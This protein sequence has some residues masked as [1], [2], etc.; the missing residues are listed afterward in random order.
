VTISYRFSGDENRARGIIYDARL[1][2]DR[3]KLE[4]SFNSLSQLSRSYPLESG[5]LIRV[6]SHF[7]Q[8]SIF[9]DSP[10]EEIAAVAERIAIAPFILRISFRGMDNNFYEVYWDAGKDELY[11]LKDSNGDE[12]PQPISSSERSDLTDKYANGNFLTMNGLGSGLDATEIL[13][14]NINEYGSFRYTGSFVTPDDESRFSYS[15][16]DNYAYKT[17]D[18]AG[19]IAPPDISLGYPQHPP[20]LQES[21]YYFEKRIWTGDRFVIAPYGTGSGYIDPLIG[22]DSNYTEDKTTTSYFAF[23]PNVGLGGRFIVAQGSNRATILDYDIIMGRNIFTLPNLDEDDYKSSYASKVFNMEEFDKVDI[24]YD[25]YDIYPVNLWSFD[26]TRS[27]GK[28]GDLS[29]NQKHFFGEENNLIE[30]E[31]ETNSTLREVFQH[32]PLS[33]G[34]PSPPV[35]VTFSSE[36]KIPI[37]WTINN[38]QGRTSKGRSV[39]FEYIKTLKFYERIVGEEI[40][41]DFYNDTG[42]LPVWDASLRLWVQDGRPRSLEGDGVNEESS[43]DYQWDEFSEIDLTTVNTLIMSHSQWNDSHPA[44]IVVKFLERS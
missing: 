1:L 33:V 37:L 18:E 24:T 41:N 31:F 2:L 26:R 42:I 40:V 23:E 5:D 19:S 44:D 10:F 17:E 30:E 39:L 34:A 11:A 43:Y 25:H 29:V 4:M 14:D 22:N 35:E 32:W 36:W 12:V 6:Q 27:R 15:L 38:S 13:W 3:L 21:Y 7:G 8:D 9:I 20:E 16:G 28:A